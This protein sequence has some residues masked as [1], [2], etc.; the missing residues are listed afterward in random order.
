MSLRYF[1]RWRRDHRLAEHALDP[2]EARRRFGIGEPFCLVFHEGE[3]PHAFLEVARGE[4]SVGRLDGEG[5][6]RLEWGFERSGQRLFL[7]RASLHD[8]DEEGEPIAQL[9]F[10]FEEEGQV[11]LQRSAAPFEVVETETHTFA[12]GEHWCP[13]PPFEEL[14]VLL[15]RE[16]DLPADL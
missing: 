2:E 15:H 13:E 5:F 1:V 8:F 3:R 7:H 9:A 11:T 4:L 6:C 14:P 12:A 10:F 16:P